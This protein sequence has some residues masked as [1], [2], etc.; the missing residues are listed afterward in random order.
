LPLAKHLGKSK[1]VVGT[2][3]K[4]LPCENEWVD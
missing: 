4:E 1:P 2:L 3:R